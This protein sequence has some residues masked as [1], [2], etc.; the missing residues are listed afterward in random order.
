MTG[1]DLAGSAGE[2]AASLRARLDLLPMSRASSIAV[3]ITCLLSALDGYDVLSVTF[4]APGIVGHWGIG[5]GALGLVFSAGLAGMAAGSFLVAPLADT[6]GRRRLVIANLVFM[7][8]GMIM[9]AFSGS[10]TQFAVWRIVTGIGIGAMIPIITPLSAEYANVKRRSL[11]IAIMALGYPIGGTVG[12]LAAALLL[13]WFDWRAVFLFGAAVAVVLLAAVL[14]WLVEPPV[15]MIERRTADSLLKLNAYIV[16]R[17]ATPLPALPAREQT[18]G[19]TAYGQ[20]FAPGRR[21]STLIITVINLFYVMTGYYM[22]S[23]MPQMVADAG[24]APATASAVAALAALV[25][26]FSQLAV[27]ILGGRLGMRPLVPA[28]M[29]GAAAA[30]ALFGFTPPCLALIAAMAAVAGALIYGAISG[31]YAVIVE[32]FEPA[33]RATG[34]GF[35]MG[36]GRV[37]A[38]TAPALAGSLLALGASRG[39][40]SVAL[41]SGALIAGLILFAWRPKSFPI[42]VESPEA[43]K[44]VVTSST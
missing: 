5:K 30:T 43:E 34:V 33:M 32:T 8:I 15:F 42:P 3:L 7:A 10:I 20:I 36:V 1:L 25:G 39:V 13:R 22:L 29:V 2:T 38:A 41:G 35:V 28:V 21:V 12:G 27:G 19:K 16:G 44:K 40:V 6:F 14:R 4:A 24:F 31:L 23:W 18:V 9:S 17:G 11:A 37:A 26:I